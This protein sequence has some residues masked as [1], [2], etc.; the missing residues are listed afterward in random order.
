MGNIRTDDDALRNCFQN[1]VWSSTPGYL[2]RNEHEKSLK[3]NG[4][5][6]LRSGLLSAIGCEP[7]H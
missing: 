6:S 5:R 1:T 7:N 3:K 4:M 2:I